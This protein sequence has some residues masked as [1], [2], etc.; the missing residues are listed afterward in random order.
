MKDGAKS[1]DISTKNDTIEIDEFGRKTIRN[2]NYVFMRL[3]D[4]NMTCASTL[5]HFEEVN[6]FDGYDRINI[7]TDKKTVNGVT[8]AKIVRNDDHTFNGSR[9][10]GTTT[11]VY[12]RVEESYRTESNTTF[13]EFID[14]ENARTF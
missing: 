8:N 6:S 2:Y 11:S 12:K 4:V 10:H 7:V 3:C 1:T 5:N 13:I 14:K 9:V